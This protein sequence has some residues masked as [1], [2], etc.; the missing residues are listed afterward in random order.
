MGDHTPFPPPPLPLPVYLGRHWL[1]VTTKIAPIVSWG[2]SLHLCFRAL[3]QLHE[4]YSGFIHTP[5]QHL[6]VST[7]QHVYNICEHTWMSH[8]FKS[9]GYTYIQT[10]YTLCWSMNNQLCMYQRTLRLLHT[11]PHSLRPTAQCANTQQNHNYSIEV[12]LSCDSP[13]PISSRYH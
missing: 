2:V 6:Q 13:H 1:S 11:S 3:E 12:I 7:L 4:D 8:K 10:N 9:D 5:L